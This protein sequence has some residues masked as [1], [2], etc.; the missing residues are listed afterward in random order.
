MPLSHAEPR[1]AVTAAV[2]F[3][4]RATGGPLKPDVEV[5]MKCPPAIT[6]EPQR[7][8][9]LADY[10]LASDRPLPTLDPVV[11]IARRM[12]GMP[13][14]AINMIG[15]DHVFFAASAGFDGKEVDMRRDVSF[16]A[17][18]ITQ[19][20]VMLVP[21]ATR[22]ERFHDNPL[23]AGTAGVRFYAGVPLVSPDGHAL[24][25]L[26]VLDTVPHTD[27]SAADCERLRELAAMAADR[28]ELRR[29]ELS[30]ERAR[31]PLDE[32]ARNSPTAV[33]WFDQNRDIIAWNDA[34]ADMYGFAPGE[35]AG[36]SFDTLLLPEERAQVR[37]LIERAA[38]GGS[39]DGL[40]MPALLHGVRKDGTQFV[41]GLSLFCWREGARL[42]FSVHV[43]DLTA[44]QLSNDELLRLAGTDA[45][46][47]LPNRMRFYRRV[48]ALFKRMQPAAA[49]M[50][51]LDGFKDVNDTLGHEV[52]D[53][54]LREVARRLEGR[55]GP[56]DMAARIGGDEFALLLSGPVTVEQALAA[57]QA[58]IEAVAQ[59]VQIDGQELRVTASCGVAI[60]PLHAQEGLELIG[61]ADLALSQAKRMG[62]GQAFA[63]VQALRMAAQARRLYNIELQRAVAD[64]QFL[65][66]YQPQIRFADGAMV[67]AEAL[68]RWW[69][70]QRG[71]LS[72]AAFLPALEGGPL[73]ARVGAWVLDEACAQAALWRRSGAT[74]FRI[75]VNLFS[76][77]FRV[78]DL[79]AEVLA[80]LDRHGLPPEALELEV[81]ENIVLDHDERVLA[82]LQQLR[83]HGVG[84]AF[85]DFG[86]GYASLS[87]LKRYPLTR[88]KIDRSFVRGLLESERD[89]S[90]VRAI[91]DMA[92]SFNLETVA[93][94][95]ETARQR[96]RLEHLGCVEGQG[97]L[98]SRPLPAAQFAVDYGIGGAVRCA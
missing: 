14:A 4:G 73:A 8:D 29:V 84:I 16:C 20:A 10:G 2:A 64:S 60:A 67:G 42:T 37:Q 13:V 50:I 48:E 77:Q 83:A 12:F 27:F 40:E 38:A 79:A 56:A 72:P 81:T 95:V 11:Q 6:D 62:R 31:R 30:T 61:N 41:L 70:P 65:L 52:G 24:G 36:R 21:D 94:G 26:C 53:G 47:A 92:R 25:A 1:V 18:A 69:H 5:I 75:G 49:V 51:D 71:L 97:Y 87:L 63:F 57:A 78:D 23:V 68:L 96:V 34:A 86:T 88:I 82:T 89:A 28:L 74:H 44:R 80:A 15:S 91:L 7:L 22:D 33:I 93:E 19:R 76:A 35:G 32:G 90:V 58:V 3:N 55:T 46:T 59:P 85:D 9:T 17:H 43:Q 54:I 98:F 66:Y 39:V 45:L